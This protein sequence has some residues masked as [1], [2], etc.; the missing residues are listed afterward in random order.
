MKTFI[1]QTPDPY[2]AIQYTGD[3]RAEIESL[4]P[5]LSQYLPNHPTTQLVF[6]R[7]GRNSGGNLCLKVGDYLVFH[8]RDNSPYSVPQ[9]IWESHMEEVKS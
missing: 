1:K 6:Q 7:P 8:P 2:T 9:N 4:L 3:N 5:N